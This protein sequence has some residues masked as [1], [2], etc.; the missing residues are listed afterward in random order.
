V[1]DRTESLA[2]AAITDEAIK[3]A[4]EALYSDAR[5]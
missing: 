4:Y 1:T 3:K 2:A 5:K